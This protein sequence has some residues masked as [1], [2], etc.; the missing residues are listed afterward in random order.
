MNDAEV[1]RLIDKCHLR[2][3]RKTW[4]FLHPKHPELTK[5]QLKRVIKK[6]LK[7][8]QISGE[9]LKRMNP[10]F[11][12][13]YGAWMTDL[14][15]NQADWSPRYFMVFIHINSRYAAAYPLDGKSAE[16]LL[17]ILQV[18][19]NEFKCVSLSSDEEKAMVSNEVR[20]FL[21][22]Q[23]ISQRVV[24]EQH[25]ESLSIIDRFIRTLRD[26]NIVTEKSRRESGDKKYRNF[27][28]KRM[29]KLL[30]IYNNTVHSGTGCTPKEM[31]NNK[32]LEKIYI[33]KKLKKKA[34]VVSERGYMLDDGVYVRYLL[35]KKLMKKRRFRYSRECYKIDGREGNLFILKAKDGNTMLAPRYRLLVLGAVK[36]NNIKWASTIEGV[37]KG[38]VTRIIGYDKDKQK[39][40][41]MFDDGDGR[42]TQDVIPVRN[43]RERFPTVMSKLERDFFKDKR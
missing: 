4:S 11:A 25:H 18:F 19:T 2:T 42:E 24:L 27:T 36:P 35:P 34:K 17:Q 43:L 5:E 22:A 3:F 41:V 8:P 39:Y 6:R 13:H 12:N 10:V 28:V 16:D 1:N 29:N 21:E 14:L 40:T 20:R 37:S 38:V 23:K 9:D 32:A 15:E 7:D 30:D 33:V 31:L 26:M